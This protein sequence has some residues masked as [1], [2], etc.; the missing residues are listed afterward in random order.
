M[1]HKIINT[2]RKAKEMELS[3]EKNPHRGV[4]KE[5]GK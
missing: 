3:K 2:V 4:K 1:C 5:A